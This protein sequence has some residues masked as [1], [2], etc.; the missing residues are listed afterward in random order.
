MNKEKD[1]VD[2]KSLLHRLELEGKRYDKGDS[3]T[4]TLGGEKFSF[5][6]RRIVQEI[7]SII[8]ENPEFVGM[9][10]RELVGFFEGYVIYRSMRLSGEMVGSKV[11]DYV[12]RNLGRGPSVQGQGKAI[13]EE[14]SRGEFLV[15]F[16]DG[17]VE[18]AMN[19]A[20]AEQ[21]IKRWFGMR[22]G[23]EIG[24]GTI[25][26]RMRTA[27]DDGL[28]SPPSIPNQES[29]AGKENPGVKQKW[30]VEGNMK[31]ARI[32]RIAKK[33]VAG[34]KIVAIFPGENPRN[35]YMFYYVD[36]SGR[37]WYTMSPHSRGAVQADTYEE[38]V[39][40]VMN[41]RVKALWVEDGEHV[42]SAPWI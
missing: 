15:M 22:P 40:M 25:E 30:L 18:H 3:L 23:V 7:V 35:P 29:E 34:P 32:E 9:V 4:E 11:T 38:F 33:M 42:N 41:G 27:D 24:V 1:M 16:P 12:T 8:E 19:R 20:Q 5:T 28:V 14:N 36:D 17:K 6:T 31:E 13:A 26:W 37:V 39:K 2:F 10:P 21:K